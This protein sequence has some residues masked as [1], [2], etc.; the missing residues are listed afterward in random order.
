MNIFVLED[1]LVQQIRMEKIIY[2]ILESN[3]WECRYCEVYGKPEHLL[4]DICERGN[5]Q[6]FFLDIEIHENKTRGLEIARSIRKKDPQAII[7]FVT[8]H[9]EFMSLAFQ[10][11]I[12]ALDFIDKKLPDNVFIDRIKAD[13]KYAYDSQSK[14]LIEDYFTFESDK[15]Q[16][17]V[18]FD[19][20]LYIET[21]QIPHKLILHSK[22]G[23]VEFYG[24]LSK[25]IDQ[26]DRLYQC[27]RSFVVNPYNLTRIDRR[28]RVAHF[29]NGETCLIARSKI[30]ELINIMKVHSETKDDNSI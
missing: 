26:D 3:E 8:M 1:D 15:S 24:Q 28:D 14:M 4:S 16:I 29:S 13:L 27:H 23:V 5:H 21:S 18:S 30:K 7:V 9:L 2:E 25:T 20:L 10:Y 6:I 17:Q 19:D 11:Q 12:S 22:R